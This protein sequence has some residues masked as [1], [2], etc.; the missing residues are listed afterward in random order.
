MFIYFRLI[1]SDFAA[2]TV[3][4]SFCV[5]L[6]KVSRFQIFLIGIFEVIFYALNENIVYHKLY[7][8]DVGGSI[9]IH[10]FAAYFGLA[11]ARVMHSEDIAE[12]NPKEGSTYN[13]DLFSTIGTF[14]KLVQT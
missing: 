14:R 6:G 2:A 7:I 5:V 10:V 13:S 8:T 9:P 4:I 12:E 11:V 1:T 3:L